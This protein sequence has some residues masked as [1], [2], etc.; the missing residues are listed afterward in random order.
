MSKKNKKY[1]QDANLVKTAGLTQQAE[2]SIIR[3]DLIR[4]VILN[5]IYFIG[6][7]FLY[8]S[9]L[10]THFLERWFEKVLHL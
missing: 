2:Y 9:N 8:F 1:F 3:H 5:L 10:K 4:V 7:L 6:L